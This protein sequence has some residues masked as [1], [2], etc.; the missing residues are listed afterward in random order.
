MCKHRNV[1][2]EFPLSLAPPLVLDRSGGGSHQGDDVLG[3]DD[4][5]G[6]WK[7]QRKN[8]CEVGVAPNNEQGRGGSVGKTYV[9]GRER[10][11]FVERPK[12]MNVA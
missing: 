4:D 11:N 7:S 12:E 10:G 2:T 8:V 3:C 9:Y 5:G 1:L 6:G